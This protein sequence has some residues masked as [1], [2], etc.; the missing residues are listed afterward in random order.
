MGIRPAMIYRNFHS[1]GDGACPKTRPNFMSPRGSSLQ[2]PPVVLLSTFIQRRTPGINQVGA[3][4]GG[5]PVQRF[6]LLPSYPSVSLR[7]VEPVLFHRLHLDPAALFP[8]WPPRPYNP[9]TGWEHYRIKAGARNPKAA[10]T[11]RFNCVSSKCQTPQT[12]A[13]HLPPFNTSYCHSIKQNHIGTKIFGVVACGRFAP[14][15]ELN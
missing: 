9:P 2:P 15:G 8:K 7:P 5:Q 4:P 11:L 14:R 3:E 12:S 1:G 6:D 10:I 13:S